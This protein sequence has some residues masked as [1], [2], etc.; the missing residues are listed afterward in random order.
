MIGGLGFIKL[1]GFFAIFLVIGGMFINVISAVNYGS[2]TGDFKPLLTATGGR[3]LQID[4]RMKKSVEFLSDESAQNTIDPALRL[5]MTEMMKQQLIFDLMIFLLIG[6][7]LFKLGNW[8]AGKAQL[9]PMTDVM[10]VVIILLLFMGLE[11]A[12][13]YWVTKEVVYPLSGVWEFLKNLPVIFHLP[14]LNTPLIVGNM[15]GI[16]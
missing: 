12:Y 6:F 16:V 2:K 8:L 13:T 4:Q 15:T 14:D 5:R 10:I 9:D 7:G 11:M 1:A 3:I